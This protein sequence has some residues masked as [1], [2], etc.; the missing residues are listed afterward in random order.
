MKIKTTTITTFTLL[1]VLAAAPAFAQGRGKGVG[2]G[3]GNQVQGGVGGNSRV[4]AP[5]TNVGVKTDTEVKAKTSADVKGRG[6]NSDKS[7][8]VSEK[9]GRD[10]NVAAKLQAN[11][12]LSAKLQGMLPAGRS[13]S[14]AAA[15]FRNQGQFIAALHASQNLNIPF[16]ELKA[17]RTGSSSMSLGAAIRASRPGMN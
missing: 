1:L 11:P 6:A 4:Q 3:L 15:G 12:H 16:D 13:M 14:D 8:T 5:G 7:G 10:S 9:R 17:K 2:V